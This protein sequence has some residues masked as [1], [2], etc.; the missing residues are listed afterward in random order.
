MS[1]KSLSVS[2]ASM[3]A[4]S[5][6]VNFANSRLMASR[7]LVYSS[8]ASCQIF[9]TQ[10]DGSILGQFYRQVLRQIGAEKDALDAN[11]LD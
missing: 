1:G 9:C 2:L 5:L 4:V 10:V 8:Q 3:M 6:T 7:S 11:L